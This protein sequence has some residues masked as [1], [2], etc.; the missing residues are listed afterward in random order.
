VRTTFGAGTI[1]LVVPVDI[2]PAACYTTYNSVTTT[3]FAWQIG[4]G[5]DYRVRREGRMTLRLGQFDYGQM[6]K[7]GVS[8]NS[9]KLGG[10]LTF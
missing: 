1:R 8:V 9:I 2:C 7:N 5:V 10:G 6:K 4:G 3:G